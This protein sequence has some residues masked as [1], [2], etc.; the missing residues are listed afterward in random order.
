MLKRAVPLALALALALPCGA[1]YAQT[2]A[3]TLQSA[4]DMTETQRPADDEKPSAGLF[5]KTGRIGLAP[6]ALGL[7]ASSAACAIAWKVL[8]REEDDE[9]D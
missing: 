3:V 7:G 6:L 4:G 1:A 2:T 5:G 9:K 8:G